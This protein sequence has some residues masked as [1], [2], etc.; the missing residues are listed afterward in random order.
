MSRLAFLISLTRQYRGRLVLAIVIT[1]LLTVVSLCPPLALRYLFDHVVTPALKGRHELWAQLPLAL[2]LFVSL[3]I[4]VALLTNFN[5]VFIAAIGQRLVVD[6]RTSFYAHV[7]N[8]DMRFHASNGSGILMNR[9][10]GDVGIVQT[11]M[12]GETLSIISSLVALL[13][14]IVMAFLI[15]PLL[16]LVL[17]A[18]A[19][20]CALNYYKYSQLIRRANLELRDVMDAISGQLQ[21]RLAGVRLVKIYNRERDETGAVP[22]LH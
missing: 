14:C 2:G 3:P 1:M 11:M 18:S 5:R 4:L 12:T 19:A 21:E 16:A 22:C 6:L 20:L 13:F 10:M 8:L 17:V 9:L 7:L 15:S